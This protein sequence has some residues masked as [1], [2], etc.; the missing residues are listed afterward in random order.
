MACR[1]V[2][3]L[4]CVALVVFCL[5]GRT[6]TAAPSQNRSSPGG[7]VFAYVATSDGNIAGYR[8]AP[9]T[10]RIEP[11][12]GKIGITIP[13]LSLERLLLT[14]HPS[15]R[16]LYAASAFRADRDGYPFHE[17]PVPARKFT[18]IRAYRVERSGKLTPVQTLTV[19]AAVGDLVMHPGGSRLY[20][21]TG[22]PGNNPN[23][24]NRV[25]LLRVLPDG[26]LRR[27]PSDAV[28]DLGFYY[29]DFYFKG[30][31]QFFFV[32]GGKM[33]YN[34]TVSSSNEYYHTY[35]SRYSVPKGGA[36]V[37]D[38][39]GYWVGYG[40]SK[41]ATSVDRDPGTFAGWSSDGRTAFL[42]SGS[43]NRVWL[44]PVNSRG[45]IQARGG[46]PPYLSLPP[47]QS[48]DFRPAILCAHPTRPFVY[49]GAPG[50]RVPCSAYKIIGPGRLKHI[51]TFRSGFAVGMSS[52]RLIAEP[53]GRFL[54]EIEYNASGTT[55]V[56]HAVY[57]V[58]ADGVPKL[59]SPPVALR[60]VGI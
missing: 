14:K 24:G 6:E 18:A 21:P 5:T 60:M 30:E 13:G 10:G 2:F 35:Y 31:W 56:R 52:R 25:F 49:H 48:G 20:A 1:T 3:I 27:E 55:P 33:A 42:N 29:E 9:N 12:P 11:L 40:S 44:C 23:A 53:T 43:S 37:A 19:P 26:R 51:G 4:I 41:R 50:S 45:Q 47:P 7:T 34:R 8:V 32:P 17:N 36:L 39:G 54:Y 38:P 16:F 22:L 59:L 46:S 15:G 28:A 57:K 58:G